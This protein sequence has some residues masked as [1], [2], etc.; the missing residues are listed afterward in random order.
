MSEHSPSNPFHLL[1]PPYDT[2]IPL[3]DVSAIPRSRRPHQGIG[4]VWN[5]S[6]GDWGKTFKA[7]R[8]RAGG[9]ALMAILPP[10]RELESAS[11]LDSW[12]IS[13]MNNF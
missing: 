5:L 2:L 8:D 1:V 4:L 10:A 3:D 12:L 11:R 9:I 7:A 13:N 6:A